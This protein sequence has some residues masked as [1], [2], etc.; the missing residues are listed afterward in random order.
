MGPS[1]AS[2]E[3]CV[4][5]LA[6]DLG[7]SKNCRVNCIS[8]SPINTVS[9]RGI[10]NF[11]LIKNDYNNKMLINEEI[12]QNNIGSLCTYLCS[13]NSKG[14]TGQTIYRIIIIYS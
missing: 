13:D 4:K 1:K 9:A 8:P 2:L 11:Q 7:K 5:Y 6:Y 10:N 14:I 12:N 3:S